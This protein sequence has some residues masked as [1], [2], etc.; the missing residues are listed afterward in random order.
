M[1]TGQFC[2]NPGL[3]VLLAARDRAFLASVA[4]KFRAPVGTLLSAGVARSLGRH[5][6]ARQAAGPKCS[7][8]ARG[9]RQGYSYANTLLRVSGEQ[10]WSAAE[11][12]QTEAFGNASL[13]VV[14]DNVEQAAAILVPW[15]AT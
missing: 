11:H 2:T 6:Q 10:F 15:K 7:C 5:R 3:V 14:A 13:A 9:G 1:G 8:G 12:Y 4:E